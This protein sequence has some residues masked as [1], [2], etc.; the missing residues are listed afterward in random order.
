M[1]PTPDNTPTKNLA[2]SAAAKPTTELH[3]DLT[4]KLHS[5]CNGSTKVCTDKSS[6]VTLP[7][8]P[9]DSP[10]PSQ[11]KLTRSDSGEAV[12]CGTGPATSCRGTGKGR[13]GRRRVKSASSATDK[14]AAST[15]A[16]PKSTR[17]AK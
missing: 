3:Q 17:A 12:P 14:P 16:K 8:S 1:A 6:Q 15:T 7:V 13:Q 10:R 9:T 11:S 4:A 2:K 5:Y